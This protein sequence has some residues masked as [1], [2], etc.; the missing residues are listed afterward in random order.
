MTSIR[1][2]LRLISI[3]LLSILSA[4]QTLPPE[5][6]VPATLDDMVIAGGDDPQQEKHKFAKSKEEIRRAYS[7]YLDNATVDEKTRLDALTRLAELEYEEGRQLVDNQSDEKAEQEKRLNTRLKR[8]IDLLSTSIRDYPDAKTN[9]TLLYQLARAQAEYGQHDNSIESLTMLAEKYPQSPHYAEAQ[10]RIGE[11]SFSLQDY[12]AAE[13][14]YTEVIVSPGNDIF[15]EK[16]IFKRGWARFKQ[17]YYADAIEDFI[18]AILNHNFDTSYEA[19][20]T[21]DKNQIDEYIRAIALSFTYQDDSSK[22]AEY[23]KR[24]QEFNYTFHIY[25]KITELYL[26]QE[27]YSDAVDIQDQFIHYFKTSEN[28]PYAYLRKIEIWKDGGF[29][30]QIYAAIEDFFETFNPDSEYWVTQNGNSRVNRVIRRSLRE[31]VVLITGY[32]HN[33]Y[34]TSNNTADYQQAQKWYKRYL[35]YYKAYARKDNIFFLY[36]ELLNERKEYPEALRFFESATFDNNLI[37]H[38]EAAYAA[39]VIS[40]QLFNN[41]KDS[42]LLGK[43]ILYTK[44]FCRQFPEDKRCHEISLHAAEQAYLNRQYRNAIELA[45]LSLEHNRNVS[46][47]QASQIKASSYFNLQEYETSEALYASVLAAGNLNKTQRLQYQSNLALSI[48]RL[49]E[50]ALKD[51]DIGRAIHHYSRISRVVATTDIASTGLYDAIALNMEY[52]QWDGAI[53]L[54]QRFQKLY[55][56]HKYS[57]DVSKKLSTAYLSSDQG[58]KA[59]EEFEKIARIDSD[60]TVK[61]AAQWKAAQLYEEKGRHKQAIEAYK[62]YASTFEKPYERQLAAM[63]RVASLYEE[64]NSTKAS[65]DWYRQIIKRDTG[66]LNNVRTD[67]SRSITSN[68]YLA[69]AR[70]EKSRFDGLQLTLP[71]KTT[72]LRKKAAM[73]SAVKLFG[74]ASLNKVYDVTTEAT[75]S[76]ASIYYD[77]SNALIESDRPTGL[78]ADELDQYEILLEDQAFPFEDKA[79]EFFEINLSRI[80]E[81]FY[82]DWIKQSYLELKKLFPVR[83]D[84]QPKLDV[85]ELEM[86]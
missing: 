15:L 53:N 31:Y 29:N 64:S 17:E 22:L 6:R 50:T 24:R 70:Y 1:F 65:L 56:S 44:R 34:Q 68:A 67:I 43:Y 30:Q 62:T 77:F 71:L 54:I 26:Q 80:K 13:Y 10:F 37:L 60:L 51:N 9:D 75:F 45:D 28:I 66:V 49:A 40:N 18:D 3:T 52:R 5:S 32:F 76:I 48:Y 85:F 72:L 14:A 42:A 46:A 73:Q 7:E 16:S 25:Q 47:F 63:N 36:G 61:A 39:I 78:N 38:K 20:D 21:V 11:D 57:I 55:P 35:K 19:L 12:S 33:R 83:Y 41:G 69:L 74:N 81:D 79:I 84:R 86:E 23:L 8:T 2:D 27:R 59:A 58:I 4:C 82:N